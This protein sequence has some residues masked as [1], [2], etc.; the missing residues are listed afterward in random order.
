MHSKAM[1]LILARCL[2]QLGVLDPSQIHLKQARPAAILE[3]AQDLLASVLP[4]VLRILRT[5]L[6]LDLVEFCTY[7]LHKLL[8]LE[9]AG[10]I[11]LPCWFACTVPSAVC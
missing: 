11:T 4:H 1:Y 2:G 5:A 6:R 8:C 3:D 10:A 7:A 9:L